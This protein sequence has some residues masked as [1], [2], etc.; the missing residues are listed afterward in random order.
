MS[1]KYQNWRDVYAD[2]GLVEALRELGHAISA[3]EWAAVGGSCEESSPEETASLVLERL[4]A[5]A[6]SAWGEIGQHVIEGV[7]EELT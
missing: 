3:W 4:A 7:E 2:A 5:A 1:T 6:V